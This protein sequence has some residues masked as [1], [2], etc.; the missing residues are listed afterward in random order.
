[1]VPLCPCAPC[2]SPPSQPREDTLSS[3]LFSGHDAKAQ[4]PARE[5]ER[6]GWKPRPRPC[7]QL[8]PHSPWP[9]EHPSPGDAVTVLTR[10]RKEPAEG[11]PFQ[12]RG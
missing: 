4:S 2:P 11:G 8:P 5:P 9:Q 3:A 12:A 10:V 1:M 6:Q 7:P